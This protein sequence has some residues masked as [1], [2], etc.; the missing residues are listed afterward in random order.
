[1]KINLRN[2]ITVLILLLG[3]LFV[4]SAWV[5]DDTYITM[6][7]VDNFIH[8]Y[9]LR[10]N[11]DE[12]VQVFT[13]P[14]WMLMLAMGYLVSKNAFITIIGL[15]ILISFSTIIIFFIKIPRTILA[16]AAGFTLLLFSKSF[17][18]FSVSGL[19]NPL[20]H[21][22]L[23]LFL[24]TFLRSKDF[25]TNRDIFLLSLLAGLATFN[26]MDTLLLF[27]P[28]LI[29]IFWTH[30]SSR[31]FGLVAAGF[32]PFILWEL[33]SLAYYGFLLPNTFYAKLNTGISTFDLIQQGFFYFKNSLLWD[34]LTLPVIGVT[35]GLVFFK[36]ELKQKL[37]AAGILLYLFYILYIGGDYMSGR[38]FSAPYLASV[39]M[40][41]PALSSFDKKYMYM[42]IMVSILL[43]MLAPFPAFYLPTLEATDLAIKNNE[44]PGGITDEKAYYFQSASLLNWRPGKVYP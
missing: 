19:E 7:V 41:V 1:M 28:M 43:G 30:R 15:S 22:L 17:I 13:H 20:T 23:I 16:A 34:P 38:F 44:S 40:L 31:T 11:V 8:G 12:R 42:P 39:V 37:I 2:L 4:V 36:A 32:V 10:W 6:R 26:R 5:G 27:L 9:G 35:L 21:L 33:F 3:A 24:I 25:F 18:D 29:Y 14:F